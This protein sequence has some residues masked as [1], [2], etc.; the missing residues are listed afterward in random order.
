M[1]P[2]LQLQGGVSVELTGLEPHV[3][4]VNPGEDVIAKIYAFLQND[5][6]AAVYILCAVG[7]VSSVVLQQPGCFGN[8]NSS[9][10]AQL[11]NEVL[12]SN[13]SRQL[14]SGLRSNNFPFAEEKRYS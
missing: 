4:T 1:F 5:P 7:T 11:E 8:F 12:G 14:V 13:S 10:R 2:F 6:F 9:K 3:L